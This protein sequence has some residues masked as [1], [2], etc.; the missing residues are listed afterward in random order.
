MCKKDQ[1]HELKDGSNSMAE[2]SYY[3]SLIFLNINFC[4]FYIY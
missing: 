2:S 3:K 1:K 4:N